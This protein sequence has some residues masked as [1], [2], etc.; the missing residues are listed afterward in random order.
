MRRY[1]IYGMGYLLH[2]RVDRAPFGNTWI[3][4]LL[5]IEIFEYWIFY[6]FVYNFFLFL[7]SLVCI[8][9]FKSFDDQRMSFR[10]LGLIFLVDISL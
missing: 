5:L 6:V 9:K 4:I 1:C 2:T 10:Y 7:V 3:H 8:S